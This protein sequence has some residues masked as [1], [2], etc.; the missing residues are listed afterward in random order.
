MLTALAFLAALEVSLSGLQEAGTAT[1][2]MFFMDVYEVTV[3][4]PDGN[5]THADLDDESVPKRVV[6]DVLY[7]GDL[8]EIPEGWTSE[9]EPALSDRRMATIRSAYRDLN[10]GDDIVLAYSP[11]V[12]SVLRV[13]GDVV[14]SGGYDLT[15][16]FLDIWFGDT[17]VDEGIKSEFIGD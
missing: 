16:A 7:G 3:F 12:G 8:P 9:L 17:P 2:S 15:A 13:N 5:L 1:R 4:D 11:G 6:L 10:E 14:A